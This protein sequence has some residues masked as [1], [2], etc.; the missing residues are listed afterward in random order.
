MNKFIRKH[1]KEIIFTV[2]SVLSVI[3]I[4]CAL[5]L[6]NNFS[7]G[8][9][10]QAVDAVDHHAEEYQDML[11]GVFRIYVE[12]GEK[13]AEGFPSARTGISDY[14]SAL[15][16]DPQYSDIALIYFFTNDGVAH[17]AD[18]PMG[19]T[20]A[21]NPKFEKYIK[22]NSSGCIGLFDESG[23]SVRLLGVYV[24]INRGEVRAI[25]LMYH[26]KPFLDTLKAEYEKFRSDTPANYVYVCKH[27][28]EVISVLEPGE[29][30]LGK[31]EVTEHD[32]L[33]VYLRELTD[34][35]TVDLFEQGVNEG[36]ISHEVL[37]N[38]TRYVISV[39]PSR[40]AGSEN[41]VVAFY[42]SYNVYAEGHALASVLGAIIV[43]IVLII[44]GLAVYI[45]L[46]RF[47]LA[48]QVD[49]YDL[50]DAVYGCPNFRAYSDKAEELLKKNKVTKYAVIYTEI[51][52]FSYIDETYGDKAADETIRFLIKVY[53]NA[54]QQDEAYGRVNDDRFV[55]LFHYKN[56]EELMSRLKNITSLSYHC[57]ALTKYG[58]YLRLIIGVCVINREKDSGTVQKFV[59]RAMV[60]RRTNLGD[61]SSNVHVYSEKVHETFMMEAEIESKMEAALRN[62][63]FKM[64]YQPKYNIERNRPDGCEALVR[65]YD[66]ENNRFRPPSEFLPLFET[67]GFIAELDKY[68]MN[69]V[70][71]FIAESI[72]R[73]YRMI[74]VSV[75]VSRVTAS[76][77]GFFEYYIATKKKYGIRDKFMTIEF[78]ESFAYENYDVISNIVEKFHA[79][80][81]ECSIDDFG[82]GFSSY[83]ILK[84]LPMDEIKLDR[85]FIKP[86]ISRERDDKLLVSIIELGK[87]MN[88]KVTQEGVETVEDLKRLKNFGC[89]VI[90]GY[91]YAK[92]MAATDFLEFIRSGGSI[93]IV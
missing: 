10:K 73:G 48:K 38:E 4:S 18:Y 32:S 1:L 71:K 8:L 3:L 79:N 16:D 69:E 45:L 57:P 43:V 63:E 11:D 27:P 2:T 36:G 81:F 35:A 17:D 67:N 12:K 49:T 41:Y 6:I 78:T 55:L 22:S 20:A 86:G 21:Y 25:A 87:Q 82:S 28:D 9:Y 92:P 77:E 93:H 54:L 64:F 42:N 70:C 24:P 80:G 65:W 50:E 13:V 14:M 91:I 51:A 33:K 53:E 29:T 34:K 76:K 5:L 68:V 61:Q 89:D 44:I 59:D 37:I 56:E 62:N 60:A 66:A 39:K 40:Q 26:S 83:N 23:A 31:N 15:K 58:F 90:Q 88:M 74:P 47:K 85:F 52:H 84:E 46:V 7:D 19:G 30:K 75:N 72:S